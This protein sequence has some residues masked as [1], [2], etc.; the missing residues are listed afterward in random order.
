M[1]SHQRLV[2]QNIQI[3]KS[4]IN[5]KLQNRKSGKT[6]SEIKGNMDLMSL[7]LESQDIFSDADIVDEMFDFFLAASAT[8][9][10]A[11]QTICG[12]LA[13]TPTS[14]SKLRKEFD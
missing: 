14:M 4:F 8:T 9:R 11:I 6:E 1:S 13:T 5:D 12:H 7:F 10:Q 2:D 3:V